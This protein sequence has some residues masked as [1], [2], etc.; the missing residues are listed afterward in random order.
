MTEE[1]EIQRAEEAKQILKNT[2]FKDAV[3]AVEEALL[4]GIKRSPIKDSEMRE[5]LCQQYIALTSVVDQL[6]THMETG[7]LA[8]ETIKRR[9][10][11]R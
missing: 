8:A 1:E 6:K 2:L 11:S 3:Q 10:T 9:G 7:K 5:R 4:N